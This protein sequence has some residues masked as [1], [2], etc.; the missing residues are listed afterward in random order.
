[1]LA[2]AGFVPGDAAPPAIDLC[3]A[4]HDATIGSFHHSAT[5]RA[6]GSQD[7][8]ETGFRRN[9]DFGMLFELKLG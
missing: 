8:C 6:A 1:M 5:S 9:S 7:C 3:P 2:L 4:L